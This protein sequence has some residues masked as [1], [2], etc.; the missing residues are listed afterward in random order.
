MSLTNLLYGEIYGDR[1]QS[2][3]I[4][5]CLNW[6]TITA[7]NRHVKEYKS[8]VQSYAPVAFEGSE[9]NNFLSHCNDTF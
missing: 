5:D 4:I 9:Y 1:V 7:Q 6:A 3:H 2:L 8:I